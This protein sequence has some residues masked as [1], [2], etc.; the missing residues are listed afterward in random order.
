VSKPAKTFM[1]FVQPAVKINSATLYCDNDLEEGLLQDIRSIS[2]NDFVFQQAGRQ[3]T[4][5]V[6]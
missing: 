5:H 3:R 2:N 4:A 1:L 6:T